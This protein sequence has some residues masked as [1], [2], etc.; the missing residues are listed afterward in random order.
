MHVCGVLKRMANQLTYDEPKLAKA[1]HMIRQTKSLDSRVCVQLV[2][3]LDSLM[4][5]QHDGGMG[6]E[7]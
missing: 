5:L 3:K 7:R 2:L 4:N 1:S 6:D